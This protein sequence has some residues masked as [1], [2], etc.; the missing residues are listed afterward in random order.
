[1]QINL[2]ND[3]KLTQQFI[4]N[5]SFVMTNEK[6]INQNYIFFNNTNILND[7]ITN[8]ITCNNNDINQIFLNEH[9]NRT[10]YNIHMSFSNPEYFQDYKVKIIYGNRYAFTSGI[11]YTLQFKCSYDGVDKIYTSPSSGNL[12]NVIY[13]LIEFINTEYGYQGTYHSGNYYRG[14]INNLPNGFTITNLENVLIWNGTNVYTSIYEDEI[15]EYDIDPVN[16]EDININII[17]T[18]TFDGLNLQ[19]IGNNVTCNY[20]INNLI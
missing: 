16:P 17:T 11:P 5:N 13:G 12:Y 9:N 19:V 7:T 15:F 18:Y 10:S 20:Q 4:S 14:N 2:V 3:N 6:Q 1:M 8:T